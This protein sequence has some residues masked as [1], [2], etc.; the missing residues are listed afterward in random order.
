MLPSLVLDR[1]YCQGKNDWTKAIAVGATGWSP[2]PDSAGFFF[3]GIEGTEDPASRSEAG[4]HRHRSR[5]RG[6][7]NARAEEREVLRPLRLLRFCNG[8]VSNCF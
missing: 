4:A 8:G 7:L 6:A 2:F 5:R 3:N 1:L